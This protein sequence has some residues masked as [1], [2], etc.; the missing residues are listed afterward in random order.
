[1]QHASLGIGIAPGQNRAGDV[2]QYGAQSSTS[3]SSSSSSSTNSGHRGERLETML[4]RRETAL[5]RLSAPQGP[6]LVITRPR[7]DVERFRG[8]SPSTV[9]DIE[10]TDAHYAYLAAMDDTYLSSQANP[11]R[12]CALHTYMTQ[13][14][15]AHVDVSVHAHLSLA[16]RNIFRYRLGTI[17]PNF[18]FARQNPPLAKNTELSARAFTCLLKQGWLV[19]TDARFFARPAHAWVRDYLQASDVERAMAADVHRPGDYAPAF[20]Y[21]AAICL[22][23][24]RDAHCFEY[25]EL[26]AIYGFAIARPH[27]LAL[28]ERL[29]RLEDTD[30]ILRDRATLQAA[31]DGE[32]VML[33]AVSPTA[34]QIAARKACVV[35]RR[36]QVR[37]QLRDYEQKEISIRA[38]HF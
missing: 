38:H 8:S 3:S 24:V 17:H 9:H 33:W 31:L 36:E 34:A 1:M 21:F 22:N 18:F 5:A 26:L 11:V 32:R 14:Q 25:H 37:A 7:L 27:V 13:L 23:A 29:L 30:D 15:A 16:R 35:Q 2:D 4:R 6:A 12:D 28:P 20:A 19:E 10:T